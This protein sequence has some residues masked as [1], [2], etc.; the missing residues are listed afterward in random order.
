MTLV[1]LMNLRQEDDESLGSFMECFDEIKIKI[2]D[3]NLEVALH[4]MHMVLKLNLFINIMCVR[5]KDELHSLN[6]L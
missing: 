6:W 4:S 3:L 2:M 5:T 1:A